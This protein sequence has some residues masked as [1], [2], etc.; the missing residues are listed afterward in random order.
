MSALRPAAPEISPSTAITTVSA[1]FTAVTSGTRTAAAFRAGTPFGTG[2]TRAVA[3][4]TIRARAAGAVIA[5]TAKPTTA[6]ATRRAGTSKATATTGT[7]A[8]E[9][10]AASTT[11]RAG[12]TKTTTPAAARRARTAVVIAGT[13]R[14]AGA[15]GVKIA[16]ASKAATA[17]AIPARSPVIKATLAAAAP[18]S[19]AGSSPPD[20]FPGCG[21]TLLQIL[22][23]VGRK[24]HVQQLGEVDRFWIG[25]D[26][27]KDSVCEG[28]IGQG[29]GFAGNI[30][31]FPP[32]RFIK[33]RRRDRQPTGP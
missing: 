32:P 5:R 31:A 18:S 30:P 24:I 17:A 19:G 12:A 23:P 7:R 16:A 6:S 25:H 13:T 21:V 4:R 28:V 3:L 27:R 22:H 2:T 1:S 14:T 26:G 29:E 11:G 15:T 9:A 10:A 33:G 8:A 20:H